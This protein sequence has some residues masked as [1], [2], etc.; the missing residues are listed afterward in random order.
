MSKKLRIVWVTEPSHNF[1]LLKKYCDEIKFIT[2][3]Y[4]DL[5]DVKMS[6]RVDLDEFDVE[7]DAIVCSG[8]NTTNLILGKL[9]GVMFETNKI[10]VGLYIKDS[11][12][13]RDYIFR[14]VG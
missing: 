9:L 8:K 6:I 2:T 1:S 12:G 13:K 7:V 14:E 10:T 3:G 5:E 11:K 4:E